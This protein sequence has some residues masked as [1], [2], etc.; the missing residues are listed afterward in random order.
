M[1]MATY[2]L[3][4]NNCQDFCNKLLLKMKIIEKPFPTTFHMDSTKSDHERSTFDCFS[5]VL[6]KAYDVAL[7]K[8]PSVVAAAGAAVVGG[9]VGAPTHEYDHKQLL[10]N[11]KPIC[12]IL[13][14]QASKWKEIGRKLSVAKW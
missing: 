2:H 1:D 7:K 5:V 10:N 11:L 12:K 4:S 3:V 9:I 6:N 13:S 8:A 14:S